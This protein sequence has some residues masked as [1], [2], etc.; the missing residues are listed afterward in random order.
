M[1]EDDFDID[2]LGDDVNDKIVRV[3]Y[4]KVGCLKNKIKN[5]DE[6]EDFMC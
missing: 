6:R 4:V 5:K 3:K 2:K 1:F